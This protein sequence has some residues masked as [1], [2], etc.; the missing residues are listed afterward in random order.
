MTR[1]FRQFPVGVLILILALPIA[2]FAGS[3]DTV[4]ISGKLS[5]ISAKAIVVKPGSYTDSGDRFAVVYLLHGWSGNYRNWFDKIDLE[6][7]AD[8]YD[9]MIVCPDG[10]YAGWYLDSPL[11]KESK[12]ATYIG[13]DVV[14]FIDLHYHTD[15]HQISRA[16]CGLS[17][18]GHGAFYLMVKYQDVFDM[19]GCMSGMMELMDP[20]NR[21]GL[22]LLLGPYET[23]RKRWGGYSNISLVDSL[24]D[25]DHHILIDCG[26]SDPFIEGNRKLHRLLIDAGIPHEYLERFGGHSW[27]YWTNALEYHLLFF[28]KNGLTSH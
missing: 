5:G 22:A 8:R 7:L 24:K 9:I 1:I 13:R 4:L 6:D 26:I 3:A 14:A 20:A 12:Y 19:A 16:L 15:T 17:M 25:K 27:E 11:L 21:Y 23:S 28:K 10:G 18:G 2:S